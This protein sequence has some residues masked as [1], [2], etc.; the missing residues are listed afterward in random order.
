MNPKEIRLA[1]GL[2]IERAAAFAGVSGP[3]V[4]LYE[5]SPTTPSVTVR[6]KLD[7]YYQRLT[8][9][10]ALDTSTNHPPQAA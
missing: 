9:R 1:A 10:I 3:S 8:A 2:S 5:A 4:R 6:R 7:A